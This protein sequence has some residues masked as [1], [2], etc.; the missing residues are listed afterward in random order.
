[1]HGKARLRRL[2]AWLFI[3]RKNVQLFDMIKFFRRA[4]YQAERNGKNCIFRE[5]CHSRHGSFGNFHLGINA[6]LYIGD[7]D[8]D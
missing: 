2:W 1:M 3:Y 8:G 5:S 6:Y 4:E 7:Y